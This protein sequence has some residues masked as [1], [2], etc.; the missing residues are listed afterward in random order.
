[1]A[2]WVIW[3]GA[4]AADGALDEWGG[5]L[6]WFVVAA[7]DWCSWTEG[8]GRGPGYG[9]CAAWRLSRVTALS[10]CRKAR[11]SSPVIK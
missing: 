5:A 3:A 6:G 10:V 8:L 2:K 9:S 4:I 7:R 1:M 11:Y